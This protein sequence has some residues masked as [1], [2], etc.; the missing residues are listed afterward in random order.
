MSKHTPGPWKVIVGPGAFGKTYY[1]DAEG[2]GE[3]PITAV[4]NN[5]NAEANA[6]LI[7]AAPELYETLKELI[8]RLY[9]NAMAFH[10]LPELMQNE[11]I[12]K[13]R[14]ALAKVE[15]GE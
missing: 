8:N 7:S 12:N 9:H 1:I 10:E 13:G 5:G 6:H 2:Y 11:L 14:R 3:N 15:K 4:S